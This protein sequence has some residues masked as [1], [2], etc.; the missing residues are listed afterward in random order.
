MKDIDIH[1]GLHISINEVSLCY[2]YSQK[3]HTNTHPGLGSKTRLVAQSLI[4]HLTLH[5]NKVDTTS[6]SYCEL[7]S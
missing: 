5:M 4:V 3:A 2:I 6:R 1:N 7:V